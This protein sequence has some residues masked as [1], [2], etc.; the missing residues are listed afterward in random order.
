MTFKLLDEALK[1]AQNHFKNKL[2]S[3]DETLEY[4][5]ACYFSKNLAFNAIEAFQPEQE[6]HG[7]DT[8]Q[9]YEEFGIDIID[10]ADTPMHLL[11]LGKKCMISLLKQ[12]LRQN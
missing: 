10:F 4:L 5:R 2:W 6:Y 3:K 11:Y 1:N 9:K 12:R 7:S 8:W